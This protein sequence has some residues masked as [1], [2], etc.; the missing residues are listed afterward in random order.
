MVENEVPYKE[1][2]HKV[3]IPTETW[4]AQDIRKCHVLHLA[5]RYSM[6]S[7]R[8]GSIPSGLGFSLNA[9]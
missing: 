6:P 9:A 3:D 5:D 1:V 2:L 7:D 8:A 4:P